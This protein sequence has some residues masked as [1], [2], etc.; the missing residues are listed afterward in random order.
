MM[1]K[2]FWNLY[3]SGPDCICPLRT[4][5]DVPRYASTT[6]VETVMELAFESYEETDQ[7]PALS[8]ASHHN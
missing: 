1:L 4:P 7:E 5:F 2:E 3:P 6:P 8:Y